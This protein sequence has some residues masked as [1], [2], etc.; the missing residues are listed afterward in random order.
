M[1]TFLD[2][3]AALLIAVFVIALFVMSIIHWQIGACILIAVILSWALIRILTRDE[4]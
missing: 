2:W 1:N 4:R 3:L